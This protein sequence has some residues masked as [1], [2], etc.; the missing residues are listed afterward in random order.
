LVL[1]LTIERVELLD[2]GHHPHRRLTWS[3]AQRWA[4]QRL[5]P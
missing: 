4:E 1:T 2:L 3:L 5:N